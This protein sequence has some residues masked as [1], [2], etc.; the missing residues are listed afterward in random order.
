MCQSSSGLEAGVAVVLVW[1]E[2]GVAVHTWLEAGVANVADV[3][4][5]IF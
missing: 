1:L 4:L 3:V 5:P 2:A